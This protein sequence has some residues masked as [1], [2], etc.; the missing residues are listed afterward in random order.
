M[1]RIFGWILCLV[2]LVISFNY[3]KPTLC[4]PGG[5]PDSRAHFNPESQ[6]TSTQ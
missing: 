4:L 6:P 2:A 5:I 1:E 3:L